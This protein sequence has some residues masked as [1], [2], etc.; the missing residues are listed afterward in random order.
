MEYNRELDVLLPHVYIHEDISETKY[1]II[2]YYNGS[3]LEVL[4]SITALILDDIKNT[5]FKYWWPNDN[6]I[7]EHYDRYMSHVHTALYNKWA[8]IST[9]NNDMRRI[10]WPTVEEIYFEL[11]V[12]LW[13]RYINVIWQCTVYCHEVAFAETNNQHNLFLISLVGIAADDSG[14]LIARLNVSAI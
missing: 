13:R 4:T 14:L 3:I 11:I 6:E 7:V 1:D 5:R 9:S 10:D 12:R 8:L 2:C